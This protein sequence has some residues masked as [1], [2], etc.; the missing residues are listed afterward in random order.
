MKAHE[1]GALQVRYFLHKS[2]QAFFIICIPHEL[3]I[4]RFLG[5]IG[6]ASV[7]PRCD[8]VSGPIGDWDTEWVVKLS[9][10]AAD[11]A[12]KSNK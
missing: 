6:M 10:K 11:E 8:T 3:A 9:G 2:P 4:L 5:R 7:V 1:C 12:A